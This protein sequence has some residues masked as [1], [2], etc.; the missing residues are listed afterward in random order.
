MLWD[1]YGDTGLGG[2]VQECC[3]APHGGHYGVALTS[4]TAFLRIRV[5]SAWALYWASSRAI[6]SSSWLARVVSWSTCRS[7]GTRRQALRDH[8]HQRS[9]GQWLQAGHG[10]AQLRDQAGSAA[11]RLWKSQGLGAL[12]LRGICR[13]PVSSSVPRPASAPL[14]TF[15]RLASSRGCRHAR[16]GLCSARRRAA[17]P[18]APSPFAELP[19]WRSGG[20]VLCHP[21]AL[22]WPET[23]GNSTPPAVQGELGN[24]CQTKDRPLPSVTLP[25]NQR[26]EATCHLCPQLQ[27]CVRG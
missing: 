20:P 26:D 11:K 3:L 23:P 4:L 22:V 9:P 19:L 18:G 21:Q 1:A 24:C 14:Q 13:I 6:C 10:L 2:A 25:P 17:G 16:L 8:V 27:A 15:S 7:C 5:S 12:T